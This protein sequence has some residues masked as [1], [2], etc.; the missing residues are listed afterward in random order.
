MKTFD[1]PFPLVSAMNIL[2]IGGINT[3]NTKAA[4]LRY[5]GYKVAT[6]KLP[7]NNIVA[8]AARFLPNF[9]KGITGAGSYI[10][11]LRKETLRQL[12]EYPD[13]VV[14]SS[15]GGAVAMAL[16][17][18]LPES[19]YLLIAPAWN[20]FG[21]DPEIK[22]DTTIIHGANDWVVP[23]RDSKR[24]AKMNKCS[25]KVVNDSHHLPE[26]FGAILNEVENVSQEMGL[27]KDKETIKREWDEYQASY[28]AWVKENVPT[29]FTDAD[30]VVLIK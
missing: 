27:H 29:F 5:E 2:F 4:Q 1:L 23:L 7:D 9:C 6:P 21:V 22:A 18:D 13:L 16:Q 3:S 11:N 28:K 17:K 30:T 19:K 14:G 24:L 20:T 10:N 26:S 12:K 8:G 25:L 15:Q